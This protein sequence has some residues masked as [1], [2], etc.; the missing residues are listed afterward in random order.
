MFFKSLKLLP[1]IL[2]FGLV[3]DSFATS[4]MLSSSSISL[5]VGN[6]DKI[7]YDGA[8]FNTLA[9]FSNPVPNTFNEYSSFDGGPAGTTFEIF[10]LASV[11]DYKNQNTFGL[12]NEQNQF[13]T[14]INGSSAFGSK[15]TY[16]QKANEKLQFGFQSPESLFFSKASQNKD[17][18]N[19]ILAQT[20]ASNS[21]LTIPKAD[22][23][24]NSFVFQML[25]G[26]IFITT[27]DQLRNTK[28]KGATTFDQD[29]NDGTFIVRARPV[30]EPGTLCL[31]GLGAMAAFKRRRPS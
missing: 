16:T 23:Q 4:V 21:L 14:S 10:F 20:V 2:T 28:W 31:L 13:V 29:F 26:D 27:D 30:P 11:A 9:S 1:V 25:A 18:A 5:N 22:Q 6:I 12:L 3:S 17:G 15:V 24:G 7:S 19:H 8:G